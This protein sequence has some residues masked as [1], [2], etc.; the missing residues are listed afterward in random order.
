MKK[1]WKS[2][3]IVNLHRSKRNNCKKVYE[4]SCQN[5]LLKLAFQQF[6]GIEKEDRKTVKK[7]FF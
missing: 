1:H 2:D 3:E 5:D 7:F 4:K 6:D